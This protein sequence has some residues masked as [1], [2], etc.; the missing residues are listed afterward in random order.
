MVE[1]SAKLH[2]VTTQNGVIIMVTV[3]RTINPTC[4]R[5]VQ[6]NPATCIDDELK[7]CVRMPTVSYENREG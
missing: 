5:F 6:E 3:V 4:F 1:I 7:K 2:G